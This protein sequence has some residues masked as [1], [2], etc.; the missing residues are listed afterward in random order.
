MSSLSQTADRRQITGPP[1]ITCVDLDGFQVPRTELWDGPSEA[2]D[3]THPASWPAWTD[4][5][6]SEISDPTEVAELELAEVER[7]T[8]ILDG[9]RPSVGEAMWAQLMIEGSLPPISGG[10]P[11]Y[12][13][14]DRAD[15]EA[16]LEQV[17]RDYPPANQISDDERGQLA[18]HGCV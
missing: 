13:A 2:I 9:P 14:A 6:F 17:D 10:A 11:E 1:F 3:P 15:L 18:A 16:W 4:N 8:D 5:F 7:I 12:T